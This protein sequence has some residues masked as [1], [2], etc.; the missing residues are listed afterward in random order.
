MKRVTMYKIVYIND[1]RHMPYTIKY[2][3]LED[4]LQNDNE[5]EVVFCKGDYKRRMKQLQNLGYE[6]IEWSYEPS[7]E[8]PLFT[9]YHGTFSRK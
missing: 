2:K 5:I 3:Q 7:E 6:L 9:E 1:G 4:E 8:S